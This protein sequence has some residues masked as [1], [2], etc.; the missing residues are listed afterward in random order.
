MKLLRTINFTPKWWLDEYGF[1]S[2][3]PMEES[4]DE[5]IETA[6][7]KNRAL[8]ER[9][10]HLGIGE[11]DYSP[12]YIIPQYD[13]RIVAA[14]SFG[15]PRPSWEKNMAC[16]WYDKAKGVLG[17]VASPGDIARIKAPDWDNNPLL[18]E[19]FERYEADK[20]SSY[21]KEG[22]VSC[23][24]TVESFYDP[25]TSRTHK[26]I[27]YMSVVDLAPFLFGDTEF[28]TILLENDD[29]TFA[30]LEKCYEISTSY[31]DYCLK[32]FG[33]DP[34]G[35]GWGS[36]G[37]DYSCILSP[38][39]YKKYVKPFDLRRMD[40][41]GLDYINLHSCG[42]SAHLYSVW[43]EYP[44]RESIKMM[45]TRGIE[46]RLAHLRK[47]LPHTL[48]QLTLHQPQC[49][50]ENIGQSEVVDTVAGYAEEARYDNLELVVLIVQ[51]GEN[52]DKNI[53]AFCRAVDGIN[54]RL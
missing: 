35:L 13:G 38:A 7:K 17:D 9:F 53:E 36:I 20:A 37:G 52:T 33:I 24:W 39:Q 23:P 32:H 21:F 30:L 1:E 2:K 6:I 43:G 46:G 48:I 16:Y 47:C 19:T 4:L 27:G 8:F 29:F 54:E 51:N 18:N 12:D 34:G 40:E 31:A 42:A 22:R 10:G 45:Q 3:S 44:H 49:D 26:T 25:R 28:F 5:Q 41:N 15:G 50:F 11:E 14:S